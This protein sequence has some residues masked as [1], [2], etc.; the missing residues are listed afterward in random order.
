MPL[1]TPAE[2]GQRLETLSM[3]ELWKHLTSNHRL[4]NG[5]VVV[6]ANLVQ[7]MTALVIAMQETSLRLNALKVRI[8]ESNESTTRLD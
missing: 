8:Q 6:P 2:P 3:N 4:E 1:S 7:I 5:D